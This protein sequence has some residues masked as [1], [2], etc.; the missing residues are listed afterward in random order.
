MADAAAQLEA[1][2]QNADNLYAAFPRRL[3]EQLNYRTISADNSPFRYRPD[4]D[5]DEFRLGRLFAN[6]ISDAPARRIANNSLSMTVNHLRL[7]D[8]EK[9]RLYDLMSNIM[10]ELNPP[11]AAAPA[12]GGRR[13]RR[14]KSTT[15]VR[16]RGRPSTRRTRRATYGATRRAT[17]ARAVRARRLSK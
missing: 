5:N 14:G 2:R 8:E 9:K 1:S 15:R 7:N 11:A 10:N 17:S 12:A 13:R 16:V 3:R 4:D 6:A